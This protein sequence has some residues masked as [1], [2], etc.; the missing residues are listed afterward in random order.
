MLFSG[1]VTIGAGAWRGLRLKRVET[2]G[3]WLAV[4]KMSGT[5]WVPLAD[6]APVKRV[7]WPGREWISVELGRDTPFVREIVFLA[8]ADLDAV[9]IEE[10]VARA[11]PAP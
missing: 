3:R 6:V 2:D 1:V 9:E 4:S 10:L 11:K 8:P 5:M 7:W